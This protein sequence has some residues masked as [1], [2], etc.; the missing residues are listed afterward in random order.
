[1]NMYYERE[2]SLLFKALKFGSWF[3]KHNTLVFGTDKKK[4]LLEV[5]RY[6]NK[7]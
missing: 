4:F 2:N 5:Q 1:M 7:L 6:F 3:L